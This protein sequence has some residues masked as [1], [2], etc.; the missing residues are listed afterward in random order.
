MLVAKDLLTIV[1][2]MEGHG[3][4]PCEYVPRLNHAQARLANLVGATR[5]ATSVPNASDNAHSAH[6]NEGAST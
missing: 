5:L 4:L 6:I 2:E 1:K 3:E